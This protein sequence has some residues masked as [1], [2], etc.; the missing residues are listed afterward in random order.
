M[1]TEAQN[2]PSI[3]QQQGLAGHSTQVMPASGGASR[4]TGNFTLTSMD[5][6]S[7]LNTPT[8]GSTAN[9][10]FEEATEYQYQPEPSEQLFPE[11]QSLQPVATTSNVVQPSLINQQQAS[12]NLSSGMVTTGACSNSELPQPGS[13]STIQ[14]KEVIE[15]LRPQLFEGESDVQSEPEE[16]VPS[17]VKS[18]A[19]AEP[20]VPR[21][22]RDK[23]SSEPAAK[24]ARFDSEEVARVT[25]AAIN[26][27]VQEMQGVKARMTRKESNDEKI[28]KS[29]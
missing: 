2:T 4:K 5:S 9:H 14:D 15:D 3:P 16:P 1:F 17:A 10:T 26:G 12:S 29:L 6:T 21:A 24:R 13:S 25:T 7:D 20:A 23:H 22:L 19:S 8:L 11:M 18:K 27:L 28:E